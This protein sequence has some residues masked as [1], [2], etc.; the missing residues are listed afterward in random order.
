MNFEDFRDRPLL[1][2][3]LEMS[4]LDPTRHEITEVGALV[5][6]GK[7][8]E[9]KREY[10]TKVKPEHIET[11]D[12]T[13]LRLNGYKSELWNDAK[14]LREVLLE[15]NK[16]APGAMIVGF[17]VTFDWM[18]LE[19]AY[20]KYGI[21]PSFDYHKIDVLGI[22][23]AHVLPDPRVKEVKLSELCRHFEIKRTEKHRALADIKATY[24]LFCKLVA[25]QV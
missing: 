19:L 1:F 16:L 9:V 4:G 24:E 18:F 6:D 21:E 3:D 8:F 14:P 17:N 25:K 7:T 12:K 5:V 11:A 22:A 20:R 15:L 2:V 13:A 23:W 10:E